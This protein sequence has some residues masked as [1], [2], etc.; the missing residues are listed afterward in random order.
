MRRWGKVNLVCPYFEVYF[1]AFNI[2]C[3]FNVNVSPG[4][5]KEKCF[6]LF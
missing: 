4:G 5:L 2:K 3:Y 1:L 6:I